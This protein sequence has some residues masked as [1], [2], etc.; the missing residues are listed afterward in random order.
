MRFAFYGRVS[1]ED[2]QDPQSSR[3]WQIA[4][5]LQLI[6]PPGG[7]IIEEFFDIGQ[8]RSLPW[9]RRP[10]A[11][12]LLRRLSDPDRPFEAVVI[13]EP[14]R[15]FYGN[16]F[17]LTFP[18]FVHYG[19]RLWVPEVGGPIDPGSDAHEIVMSLYGGISKSER[20]RIKVRVRAAMAAQAAVEGRF[21]GGRPPYGYELADAGPHPNPSKASFGQRLHRLV[22]DPPAAAV[23][24]RIFQDF[25]DGRGLHT[26]ASELTREGIPSPSA[27]DPERNQ[28]RAGVQGAWAKSAVRAILR[29]PRYT[30]FQVWN[31]QRRD[32][33]LIDVEDVA[34][35][36]QSK[37]RW[38]HPDQWVWSDRKVH[39]PIIAFDQFEEAQKAFTTGN[40]RPRRRSPNRQY[41]LAGL[42][43]CG[44]CG[45]RM[46]GQT[47][48]DRPYYRC[49]FATEYG[50]SEARHPRNLY[51]KESSVLPG[52]DR[53]LAS[54]FDKNQIDHTCQIL[55]G[56]SE[57]DS[58]EEARPASL[59]ERIADCDRRMR[60]Y[61]AV[62]DEGADPTIVAKWMAS[63]LQERR[64]LEAR[65]GRDVPGARLTASQVR[66]LVDS[67]REIVSVLADA[68]PH[69]KAELYNELGVNLTY[70]P[71]GRV[72]V[73]MKP[74]GVTV[75]VGGPTATPSTRDP[76][77]AVLDL[78]A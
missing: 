6:E 63:V 55:A 43:H 20:T 67:L 54:L 14:Q 49:R 32:E 73:E 33:V 71:E 53:W 4:R 31:R 64:D 46:Q 42:M 7:A 40:R 74:R 61:Q 38:N 24:R 35:G 60:Q 44:V 10:E 12:R 57:P 45:R 39:E 68:D 48:H 1:T 51:V 62:L 16:Q 30:G 25:V 17:G 34:L 5:A 75:R 18:I 65:V 66:A 59:V 69:D 22:I 23:V 9:A 56:V 78:A 8:S 15:A 72:T 47:N 11:S 26:I 27:W 29:N 37:M 36:H 21:L 3:Q 13:G 50:V 77:E 41:V 2:Q 19:I 28:H 76:W 70:H 52:L 58:D